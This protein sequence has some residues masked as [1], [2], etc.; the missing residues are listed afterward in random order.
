ML[1]PE[2]IDSLRDTFDKIA[3]PINDYLIKD[4]VNRVLEAGTVTGTARRKAEIARMMQVS[5]EEVEQYLR[6]E[7]NARKADFAYWFE[8]IA[9]LICMQSAIPVEE[10]TEIQQ[11][12]LS[13][14]ELAN[15]AFENLTQTLGMIDP[16]GAFMPMRSVYIQESDFAFEKVATGAAT[17]QEAMKEAVKNLADH[18]VQS[19]DYESGRHYSLDVAIR[20]NIF[21]GMGL[22]VEQIEN[23]IADEL[24]SDGW[25]I[26]AHE[27]S[28]EDHE[29]YQ[30][31]QYTNAEYQ[32]LND[33]LK[34]RIG[35]LNC[36][37][38]AYPIILG[39]SQPMYTDKELD[40]M[41]ERNKKGIDFEGRHYTLYEATQ[42]Q[43][44]LERNIRKQKRRIVA[45]QGKDEFSKEYQTAQIKY[46]Q[47]D[48]KYR[49]FSRIA[50]MPVQEQRLEVLGFTKG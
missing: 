7:C 9:R 32:E 1:K 45:Y 37:H 30:G 40:A 42:M 24:G 13:A 36:K 27:A 21:G 6:R 48:A 14:I 8:E 17:Y 50:D 20:R 29:P 15:E 35:T 22:M 39:V 4:I 28:A 16:Y 3:E 46:R 11:I 19:I 44:L 33:S 47:L 23:H 43:R 49:Q 18:G 31:R 34:R 10:D 2:Q 38:I 5:V 25:E 41:A 26:S 12:V